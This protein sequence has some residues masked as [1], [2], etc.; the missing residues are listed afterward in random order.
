LCETWINIVVTV[1]VLTYV[2]TLPQTST[3]HQQHLLVL[4]DLAFI[5]QE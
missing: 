2:L 5:G 4:I 1:Y 3:V